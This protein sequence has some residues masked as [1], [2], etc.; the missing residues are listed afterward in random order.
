MPFFAPRPSLHPPP[1]TT[2]YRL[3]YS[4]SSLTWSNTLAVEAQQWVD[5]HLV[6]A[7]SQ[8]LSS[9]HVY[10]QTITYDPYRSTTLNGQA[11]FAGSWQASTTNDPY[12]AG[13]TVQGWVDEKNS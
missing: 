9:D 2:L 13:T 7:C 5:S 11:L 3:S 1:P 12:S 6:T 8:P 10:G 4:L